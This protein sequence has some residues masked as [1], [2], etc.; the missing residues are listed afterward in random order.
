M[1]LRPLTLA[2]P[3][4]AGVDEV[5]VEVV[6]VVEVEVAWELVVV[7]EVVVVVI[8]VPI[9]FLGLHSTS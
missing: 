9:S 4:E 8:A 3:V 1:K 2:N 5:V 7:V 6:V